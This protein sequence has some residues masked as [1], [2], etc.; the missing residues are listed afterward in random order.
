MLVSS[1][2]DVNRY[3][4]KAGREWLRFLGV[5]QFKRRQVLRIAAIRPD[6][7]GS[8]TTEQR[9]GENHFRF[10]RYSVL[11]TACYTGSICVGGVD[12]FFLMT[13]MHVKIR[14]FSCAPR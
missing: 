1:A 12:K 5:K 8:S 6:D 9:W 11:R 3:E 7:L 13:F 10:R 2:L 4:W 14:I